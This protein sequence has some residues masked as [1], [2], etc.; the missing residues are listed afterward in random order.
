MENI[1]TYYGKEY[2]ITFNENKDV[3]KIQWVDEGVYLK[4]TEA[5]IKEN[6][7]GIKKAFIL[8][9]STLSNNAYKKMQKAVI[10][11]VN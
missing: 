4:E 8:N 6:K 11:L 9:K 1:I 2:T 7:H 10:E 5:E 3:A